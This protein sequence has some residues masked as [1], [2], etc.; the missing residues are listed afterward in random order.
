[1][2]F[3]SL[4]LILIY[5]AVMLFYN[6]KFK[7]FR[8]YDLDSFE[9][10][11]H[12]SILIPFRNEAENL[13]QL[14]NS[15][16]EL[17]YPKDL[18]QIYLVDDHS[19]DDSKAI[20]FELIKKLDLKNI[21]VLDNK[22]LVKS[23]KKSAILT[24]LE[25]INSGYVITTDADCLLPEYWLSHFDQCIQKTKA[26]LIAG[27]VRIAEESTFWQK[28][29]VL[30]LMSLQVIGL[31]SFKTKNPL[32]CNAANLAHKVKTLKSLN[33][34]DSHQQHISGDDIFTLQAFH[35]AGKL[36]KAIVHPEAVVWTK[37][38]QS[39]KDLT[40]QRI[41][42][43]SKAKHY[44]N[45]TLVGLGVLVF[46]TNLILVLSIGFAL[47]FESFT[48]GFWLLW[49]L[50]LIADFIILKTGNQFFKTG[51]CSKD[52]FFLLMVYPFV[53]VYFA[54]LSFGGKF[55]WKGRLYKI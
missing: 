9:T 8:S 19:E 11:T 20:C 14:L 38:Q 33:A 50:K 22:D 25:Q 16:S 27:P 48:T 15:L 46:L 31:S 29:Q 7:N 53:S 1:M 40:Q 49:I 21:L 17:N 35:Q 2:I 51:L 52:Y 44:Q 42:W 54:V 39:F 4:L 30:D 6:Y 28:F 13:P 43:A 45:K 24:A 23:P 41:R 18:F 10:Q 34:F 26:D 55:K 12:F 3:F 5:M 37:A 36:T 47:I 32:M